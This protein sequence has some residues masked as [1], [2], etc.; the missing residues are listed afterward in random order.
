MD[1]IHIIVF[2]YDIVANYLVHVHLVL[3]S[4]IFSAYSW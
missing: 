1:G 4:L 3:F 2:R